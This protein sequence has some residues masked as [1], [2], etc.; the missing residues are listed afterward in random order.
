MFQQMADELLFSAL[1]LETSPTFSETHDLS[2]HSTNFFS[3]YETPC[4]TPSSE[5]SEF[6]E[7]I[8]NP[9]NG[10]HDFYTDSIYSPEVAW[11]YWT[12]NIST[13][14][15][16]FSYNYLMPLY[17]KRKENNRSCEILR[18]NE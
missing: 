3:D 10:T 8:E 14:A 15:G 9:T 5:N 6:L 7:N 17:C 4:T 12:T 18:T 13:P 11:N 2:S 1:G 16:K